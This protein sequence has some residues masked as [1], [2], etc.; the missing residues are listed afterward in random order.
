MK[1]SI[2]EFGFF[3]YYTLD[4]VVCPYL[5]NLFWNVHLPSTDG[6]RGEGASGRY[7]GRV[8]I[9]LVLSASSVTKL[10][11]LWLEAVKLCVPCNGGNSCRRNT[12]CSTRSSCI[13]WTTFFG[14]LT[15]TINKR[16]W[17]FEFFSLLR[18][19]ELFDFFS[20]NPETVAQ[21]ICK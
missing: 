16:R 14:T 7:S 20:N 13:L 18:L 19:F 3:L 9:L 5:A 12:I 17:L 11:V 2:P 8:S 1:A 10:I 4:K 21:K 15:V 6:R